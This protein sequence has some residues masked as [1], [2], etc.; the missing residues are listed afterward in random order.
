MCY[1]TVIIII[2]YIWLYKSYDIDYV[3]N[4]HTKMYINKKY[5]I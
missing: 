4:H 3:S 2:K 5:L 1:E